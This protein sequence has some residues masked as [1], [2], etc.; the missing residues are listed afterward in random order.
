MFAIL[1]GVLIILL[2]FEDSFQA[3]VLPRR[4]THRWRPTRLYYRLL[5]HLA[6]CRPR[7]PRRALSRDDAERLWTA[8]AVGLV[9]LLGHGVDRGFGLVHWGA[10][11]L[12]S[13]LKGE[14][15]QECMYFSGET[16]FTLGYGDVTPKGTAGKLLSVVE[17]GTGFGFMALIIGYLPVLYQAFSRR[18]QDISLLDARAGSPPTAGEFLRRDRFPGRC[19][20]DGA[21]SGRMG[22]V[23]GQ[24]AGESP[25]FSG[26]EL[27]PF[28]ARQPIVAGGAGRRCSMRRP[29]KS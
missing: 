27:L 24:P 9:R 12:P 16:F 1:L 17:A 8:V 18:E 19:P 6:L 14:D 7:F 29:C 21:V 20:R 2:A 22:T 25:L 23:V 3:M 11:T 28:A 10:D 15:L 13:A 26:V 5:A 4:V